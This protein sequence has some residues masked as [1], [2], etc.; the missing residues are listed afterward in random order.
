MLSTYHTHSLFCDGA[1]MP[2]DY[3]I[4][5]IEKGFSTLG[6]SSHAPVAFETDWT[7]RREN[8]EKY[9]EIIQWL[10]EKYKNKIQLYL[11]LETDY[12]PGG[13]DY[14]SLPDLDF[15][16]G[17]V[18]FIYHKATNRYMALDGTVDEFRETRDTVFLG[19]AEKLVKAYYTLLT[20]MVQKRTPD[21]VGHLDILKKNNFGSRFFN[22]SETWYRSLVEQALIEVKAHDV[23]VEVNTGGISRGYTKEVYPSGWILKM[24]REMDIPI[25][26]NSDAHHPD[27]IDAYYDKALQIIK[28]AGYARQRVLLDGIWQ[29]VAL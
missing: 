2:E 11:G 4:A 24:M 7:M 28:S 23:I 13:P 20:E 5:A 14:R 17:S 12:Y 6:F 8:L 15:T 3:V 21:I 22:E 18:H 27:W 9:I 10:K 16:I 26:L 1:M 29:D 25:V 19:N